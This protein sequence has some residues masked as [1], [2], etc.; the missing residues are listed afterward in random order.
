MCAVKKVLKDYVF[1]F[2]GATTEDIRHFLEIDKSNE[3][4]VQSLERVR[5]AQNA[6]TGDLD[7]LSK[8][9]YSLEH[10]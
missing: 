6:Y 7:F 4:L 3:F 10:V 8:L 1:D 5:V 2:N 9:V